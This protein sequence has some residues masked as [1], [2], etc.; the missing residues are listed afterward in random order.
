MFFWNNAPDSQLEGI[1]LTRDISV[2]GVFVF[3]A[4][5]P[6][7]DAKIEL[8]GFLPPG[9]QALPVRMFGHGHVV[10]VEPGPRQRS[11]RIRDYG[12][13]DRVSQR[14]GGFV[15]TTALPRRIN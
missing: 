14:G 2:K 9:G 1:G 10:R 8:K 7:A 3:T 15:T 11:L 12:R 4:T 6:P 5:P 13:A